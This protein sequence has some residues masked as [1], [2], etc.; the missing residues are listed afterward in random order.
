MT[1][2]EFS[3]RFKPH[4]PVIHIAEAAGFNPR[5]WYTSVSRGRNL[6]ADELTRL[7][8]AVEAH[9]DELRTMAAALA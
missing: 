4:V 9:A 1:A 8:V 6:T 7:R 2:R 3:D 5:T